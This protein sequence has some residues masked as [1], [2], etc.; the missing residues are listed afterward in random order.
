[1]SFYYHH[2][3]Y[4]HKRFSYI[5]ITFFKFKKPF[6]TLAPPGLQFTNKSYYTCRFNLIND[7][8]YIHHFMILFYK[9]TLLYCLN[10]NYNKTTNYF[11]APPSFMIST[12]LKTYI[13][14]ILTHFFL[15]QVNTFFFI[16][17]L[18][19]A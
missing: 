10:I 1:M 19:L 12:V 15:K 3:F 7:L 17:H 16:I 4:T 9:I 18:F 5:K 8:L 6:T 2:Y 11:I 14:K 13:L